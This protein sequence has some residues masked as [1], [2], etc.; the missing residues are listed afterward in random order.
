MDVFLYKLILNVVQ[1]IILD[2]YCPRAKLGIELD[3][4]G[5]F[6]PYGMECD[7]IKTEIL[8]EYG[9]RV[10]HIENEMLRNMP[11]WVLGAIRQALNGNEHY[12]GNRL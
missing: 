4:A 8:S 2:F 1:N 6:T 7:N 12:K 10:L 5:H 11:D 3:G 9:I